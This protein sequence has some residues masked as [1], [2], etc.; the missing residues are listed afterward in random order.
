MGMSTQDPKI[1]E[2]IKLLQLVTAGDRSVL[3][4]ML[5]T[6]DS[7]IATIKGTPNDLLW[8]HLT[9]LGFALEMKLDVELP[10]ALKHLEP[11][12][13][14]LTAAGRSQLTQLLQN[15]PPEDGLS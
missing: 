4:A 5:E 7:Q 2:L 8:S 3:I 13:F 9:E 10:A 6:P 12:S 15:S 14:A 1:R 11:R